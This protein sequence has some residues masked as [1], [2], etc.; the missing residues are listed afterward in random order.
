M[1]SACCHKNVLFMQLRET[2]DLLRPGLSRSVGLTILQAW[3]V[4]CVSVKA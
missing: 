4:N 2:E 1:W 3:P